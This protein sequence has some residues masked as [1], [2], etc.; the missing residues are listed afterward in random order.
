[1]ALQHSM[2]ENIFL[3]RSGPVWENGVLVY[4]YV[5]QKRLDTGTVYT[6][7][8]HEPPVWS[9]RR[10]FN[11]KHSGAGIMLHAAK[12]LKRAQRKALDM[13]LEYSLA[14]YSLVDGRGHRWMSRHCL[15]VAGTGCRHL[16]TNI[17]RA[18]LAS[19]GPDLGSRCRAQ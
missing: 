4:T 9:A 12:R 6:K 1:M 3:E 16:F 15:A 2:P 8:R 18:G 5:R 13:S 17:C 14:D 10:R 19:D 11:E 7:W